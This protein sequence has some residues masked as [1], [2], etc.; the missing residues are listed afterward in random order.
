MEKRYLAN[1][2]N[3]L[4]F[5]VRNFLYVKDGAM[6]A[7][8][9]EKI[10]KEFEDNYDKFT[11]ETGSSEGKDQFSE[12]KLGRNDYQLFLPRCLDWLLPDIQECIFEGLH[13]YASVVASAG[14]STFVSS[15]AKIQK[16]P[17]HG[18]YSVWHTEQGPSGSASRGLVWA[19]YLNDVEEG[20]ETEFLYQH[21][22][23]KAKQGRLVIWPAGVTHPHRGNPPYSN[24]KY[25]VT[26]WFNYPEVDYWAPEYER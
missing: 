9:C 22:R 24:E 17:V 11:V 16:T 19:I 10:I 23:V 14:Q 12:G 26:G 18:G 13:E 20:G 6:D 3:N 7:M 4:N 15:V 25:I 8:T 5:E 21:E 1:Q 2:T